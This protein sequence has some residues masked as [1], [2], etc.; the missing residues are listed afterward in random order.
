MPI[1]Q[2]FQDALLRTKVLRI[3]KDATAPSVEMQL[4]DEK[5]NPEGERIDF[6]NAVVTFTM[7][8]GLGNA[9][10]LDQLGTVE[11]ILSS[12][13]KYVWKVGDTN[14]AGVFFGQFI[15][16]TVNDGT[17]KVPNDNKQRLKIIIGAVDSDAV[18]GVTTLGSTGPTGDTGPQNVTGPTGDSGTIGIDGSTG[19]QG[20]QG[21]TGPIGIKGDTGDIGLTGSIGAIGPTGLKGNTGDI[22]PSGSDADF[23][24]PTGPQGNIG[25]TGSIGVTG[26]QGIIG[27][28]GSTGDIGPIGGTGPQGIQ[29]IQGVTGPTGL[30]GDTGIT[31][32][33]GIQGIT[34]PTGIKGDTGLKGDTGDI[35]VTGPTGE[36]GPQGIQGIQGVT[37]PT[38]IKGDTG[39]IGPIGST[40]DTGP[41]GSD[42]NF[43]GPTGPAGLKGDTGD[44]GSTGPTGS[45]GSTGLKGDAGIQG[46]T[47]DTGIIGPIGLTGPTGDIG[48]T[49]I[50]GITGPT[51]MKGDT[52]ITGQA[53]PTGVTGIT[54][55]TGDIG[56][57]GPTG[58]SGPT[59]TDAGMTG[60]TGPPGSGPTG[61]TG[62]GGSTGDTGD[63]S[64]FLRRDGGNTII[65]NL[66]A[67][68]TNT[69]SLGIDSVAFSNVRTRAIQADT[70]QSLLINR[71][72]GA[73]WATI[74]NAGNV[75]FGL[76]TGMVDNFRFF[77]GS[78][79]DAEMLWDTNQTNDA[80]RLILN[81]SNTF[82]IGTE[83][84]P[85]LTLAVQSNPTLVIHDGSAT[86]SNW[87]SIAHDGSNLLII[88]NVGV[89]LLNGVAPILADGSVPLTANWDTG[90]FEILTVGLQGR[91]AAALTLSDAGGTARITLASDGD[92]IVNPPNDWALQIATVA[93]ITVTSTVTTFNAAAADQDHIFQG[94]TDVNLLTIDGGSDQVGVGVVPNAKF[95]VEG[96]IKLRETN[97][98]IADTIAY[99][100]FWVRDDAPNTPMFTDDLGTDFV[101]NA[102]GDPS[103]TI[104]EANGDITTTSGTDVLATTMTITPASGTYLVWFSGST[105]HSANSATIDLSIYSGGTIQ[106]SS[107][108]AFV[109]GAGQGNVT[110]SFACMA[111]VT[112]NGSQAIEGRWRTST[113]TAT[114]H[115]RTLMI[116]KVA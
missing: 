26:S 74:T 15:V 71:G 66:R 108:R 75:T 78:A 61:P 105:D 100:Q 4:L 31:G 104:V 42:A 107:E 81:G 27:P 109:R 64:A 11:D 1:F 43:T 113:S 95:T 98:A 73:T 35:G 80:F 46:P 21:I 12:I 18:S 87:G 41:T 115:E 5:N 63:T 23:T 94:D 58:V 70:G 30:K 39:D 112:V 54:G 29:G 47:G 17:Y 33:Q 6:T 65:G 99:G 86:A 91:S 36:T 14:L 56:L 60:P 37:G 111:K 79:F 116:L 28:T 13:F 67:D 83:S 93:K 92:I 22:G 50:Q 62:P 96:T 114:M 85:N 16:V 55:V 45:T 106:A 10:V 32:S 59:G 52:G 110:V 68:V 53:G 38:G 103:S 24:G 3:D 82:I 2:F 51:G 44:I 102:G 25:P 34:G 90:A 88:A 97:V 9:K 49:G 19:P 101:L 40:G 57:T 72:N 76:N 20:A 8:D 84:T 48:P 69:R 7:R 89:V 77:W